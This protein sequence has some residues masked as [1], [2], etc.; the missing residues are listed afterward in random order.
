MG[1]Y[2][3]GILFQFAAGDYVSGADP[4]NKKRVY[5]DGLGCGMVKKQ[6]RSLV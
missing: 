3:G 4:D 5:L 2:F 6:E 1:C